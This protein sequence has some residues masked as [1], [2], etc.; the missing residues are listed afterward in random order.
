MILTMVVL[1]EGI[2]TGS[3]IQR[4]EVKCCNQEDTEDGKCNVNGKAIQKLQDLGE[5]CKVQAM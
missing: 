1:G 4:T 5:G 3:W 2:K